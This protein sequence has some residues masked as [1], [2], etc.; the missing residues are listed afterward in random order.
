MSYE[1]TSEPEYE[2]EPESEAELEPDPE[3]EAELEPEAVAE[4][5]LLSRGAVVSWTIF[6]VT[7]IVATITC[8]VVIITLM[9]RRRKSDRKNCLAK[10]SDIFLVSLLAARTMVAFFVMPSRILGLFPIGNVGSILCKLCEFAA[11]GSAASS[12]LSTCAVAVSKVNETKTATRSS[13]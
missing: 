12:V 10:S 7:I 8:N 9:V 4:P 1:P 2:P 13:S 3:S 11:T 5:M 6:Y